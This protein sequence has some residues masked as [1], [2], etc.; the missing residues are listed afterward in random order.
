MKNT[1]M[2]IASILMVVALLTACVI[3]G[4]FAKYVTKAEGSDTAR[5]AKFGVVIAADE[6]ELFATK[7]ATDEKKVNED[8]VVYTG[9]FSVVAFAAEGADADKVVAPGTKGELANI[10][11]TGKP[12]VATRVA[13]VPT[14]TLTGWTIETPATEEGAEPTTEFYFPIVIK[15]N[16]TAVD[17]SNATDA[18]GVKAAIESAIAAL[19][20]D[21][22]PNFEF[23]A[24]DPE[25]E[26]TDE[27]T[28]NIELTWEWVFYVDDAT[29]VKDTYLGN[30]AAAGNASEITIGIAI[31][32]TQID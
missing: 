13:I 14:V 16:G 28:F 17:T 24:D 6:A 2:R 22:D 12:E 20:K 19:S 25:T 26:D 11:I 21:Y 8:D 31:S 1:M 10:S 18:A 27:G 3:S 9:E 15:V 32:V 30:Q 29:D 4:T 23:K 5:V 7:Y